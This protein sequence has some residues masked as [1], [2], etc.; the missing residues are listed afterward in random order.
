MNRSVS[1]QS[2]GAVPIWLQC[3]AVLAWGRRARA[4]ARRFRHSGR[5]TMRYSWSPLG[6]VVSVAVYY[7]GCS[8]RSPDRSATLAFRQCPPGPRQLAVQ[9]VAR[10]PEVIPPRKVTVACLPTVK[11]A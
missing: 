5:G 9:T 3:G 11:A 4:T 8:E 10:A 1:L 7:S 6:H 2:L